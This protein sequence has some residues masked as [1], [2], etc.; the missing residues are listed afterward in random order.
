MDGLQPTMQNTNPQTLPHHSSFYSVVLVYYFGKRTNI[1]SNYGT[2]DSLVY[3]TVAKSV[4]MNFF[5]LIVSLCDVYLKVLVWYCLQT[6]FFFHVPCNFRRWK[7]MTLHN[8]VLSVTLKQCLYPFCPSQTLFCH[9]SS[10]Q[11]GQSMFL[12]FIL[13]WIPR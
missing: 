1:Y 5:T 6:T 11:V 13:L 9:H 3:D 12:A 4:F 7:I 2:V 10:R 8:F